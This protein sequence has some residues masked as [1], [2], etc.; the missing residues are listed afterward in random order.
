MESFLRQRYPVESGTILTGNAS[1]LRPLADDLWKKGRNNNLSHAK[2]LICYFGCRRL[3]L[4]GKELA[5]YFNISQPSV[6]QAIQRGE[7]Y[8]K[9][10]K[11]KLLN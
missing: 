1:I 9:E 5:G 7:R 2:G 8:A 11:I 4:T 3:G 6:S 10:N